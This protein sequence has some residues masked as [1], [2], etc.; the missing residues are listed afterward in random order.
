M[1][2]LVVDDDAFIRTSLEAVLSSRSNDV[3]LAENA[4][5]ALALLEPQTVPDVIVADYQ[6]PGM[7]GV[8]FLVEA[9][10]QIEAWGLRPPTLILL[11]AC[12]DVS[13]SQADSERIRVIP[14]LNGTRMLLMLL[15]QAPQQ[16]AA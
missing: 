2:I 8:D 11:T 3:Q 5:D 1:K 6:M 4:S 9:S 13:I 12:A 7:N 14:K 16:A 15:D 10:A